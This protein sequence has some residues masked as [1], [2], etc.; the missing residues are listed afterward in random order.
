MDF[1]KYVLG[2][3][4]S[5]VTSFGTPVFYFAVVLL[6]MKINFS[7]AIKLII[8]LAATE[9]VCAIIKIAYPKQRPIPRP[10]RGLLEK[11]DA[12]SFPSIHSA[13][14][15]AL[16]VMV[17]SFYS[18]ALLLSA[19]IALVIFVG[20]S[21]M[22]LRHHYFKDVIGGIVIGAIISLAASMLI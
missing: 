8:A 14:I 21:R 13:R 16:A 17:N 18:D 19:G 11:Y 10:S 7:F 3:F 5:S 15:T 20:Y 2:N 4:F 9:A 6:L 22:Y 1:S 12:G